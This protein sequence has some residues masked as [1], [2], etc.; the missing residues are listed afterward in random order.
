MDFTGILFSLKLTRKQIYTAP[1]AQRLTLSTRLIQ[2]TQ[3][4]EPMLDQSWPT[5]CDAESALGQHWFNVSC[6][7]AAAVGEIEKTKVS[8]KWVI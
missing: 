7:L 3:D 8:V 1:A 2:S 6:L 4:I 5:V